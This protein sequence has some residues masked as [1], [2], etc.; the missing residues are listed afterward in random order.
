MLPKLATK[1]LDMPEKKLAK[2]IDDIGM[3]SAKELTGLQNLLI[4]AKDR[5]DDK[6]FPFDSM[7][8][9]SLNLS[10][11]NAIRKLKRK[12]I[13]DPAMDT[14]SYL[15]LVDEIFTFGSDLMWDT[16]KKAME[17]TTA[18]GA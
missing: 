8:R 18:G 4:L 17:A 11:A 10:V 13:K 5:P 15:K 3:D 14:V 6:E 7:N 2:A 12:L 1:L 9:F 16:V